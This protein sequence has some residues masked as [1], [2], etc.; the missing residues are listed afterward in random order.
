MGIEKL[1]KDL[2]MVGIWCKTWG[3]RLN[4]EKCKVMHFNKS[5]PKAVYSMMDDVSNKS[6]ILGLETK[7][8]VTFRNKK[9]NFEIRKFFRKSSKKYRM[10]ERI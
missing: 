10:F 5:N 8:K 9:I 7:K 2:H 6:Y 3:M 1:Q 4:V